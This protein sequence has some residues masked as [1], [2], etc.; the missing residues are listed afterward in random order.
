M[1]TAK[2]KIIKGVWWMPW[3]SEAK[4][5]VIRCEKPRLGAKNRLNRGSPNGETHH[6]VW[7]PCLKVG[8]RTLGTETSQYQ[9]ERKSTETL[10]VVASESG[11][12]QWYYGN[13][14][15]QMES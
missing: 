7:Y 1:R 13:N 3:H 12:G 8:K 11:I 4:K 10:R 15:N 9:E 5:D 2:K 14:W 6:L